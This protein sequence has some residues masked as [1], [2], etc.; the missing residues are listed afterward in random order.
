MTSEDPDEG[1]DEEDEEDDDDEEEAFLETP[2]DA[3][4]LAAG[5]MNG[6]FLLAI[7]T[8][9]TPP[10]PPPLTAL[11]E[12]ALFAAA[13]ACLFAADVAFLPPPPL[14]FAEL[15]NGLLADV[16][17]LL[18]TAAVEDAEDV[19]EEESN[20][21]TKPALEEEEEAAA[22]VFFAPP[23]NIVLFPEPVALSFVAVEAEAEEEDEGIAGGK[24]DSHKSIPFVISL[25]SERTAFDPPTH[26]YMHPTSFSLPNSNASLA[27]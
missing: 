6:L 9:P 2:L 5:E 16:V 20:D 26:P 18:P 27:E 3:I 21:L 25:R 13:V 23:P 4:M 19:V 14:D 7:P 24:E 8:L 11:L 1:A 22:E 10:P 17:E 15:P 12:S